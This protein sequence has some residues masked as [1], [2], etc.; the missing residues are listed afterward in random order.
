MA[1]AIIGLGSIGARVARLLAD[2][3]EAVVL[4]SRDASQAAQLAKDLGER[5]GVAS[6]RDA[7]EQ[8]DAIVFAVL[9]D[10]IK[11]LIAEHADLLDGKLVIDP[12][13]PISF[14]EKGNASR[15]LPDGQSAGSVIASLLPAGAHFVKAFGTLPAELLTSGTNRTP[16]RAVLFYATGDDEAV[17]GRLITAAGFD[18]V[19]AGGVSASL[20]IE[21][22]GD[23]HPMGGLNG[24]LLT[25][26]E[27]RAAVAG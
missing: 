21:V 15:T 13:N 22:F 4:A 26:T 10:V 8:A 11:E 5:A 14:D 23:L 3:G 24:Q 25:A 17:V 12:S 2:G 19:K 9:F 27:A 16:E 20:R 7:I 6:V 18:P 1:T